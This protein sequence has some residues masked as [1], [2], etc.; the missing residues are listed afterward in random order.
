MPN[1]SVNMRRRVAQVSCR[2]VTNVSA[3]CCFTNAE[4]GIRKD[5]VTTAAV[6][7][8]AAG[9]LQCHVHEAMR[10]VRRSSPSAVTKLMLEYRGGLAARAACAAMRIGLKARS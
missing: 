2:V 6:S 3:T 1:N 9:V 10:G 8:A 7:R 4:F 5:A